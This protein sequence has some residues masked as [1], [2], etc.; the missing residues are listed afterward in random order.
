MNASSPSK[1]STIR[2]ILMSQLLLAIYLGFF[3]FVLNRSP[4]ETFVAGLVCALVAT[5]V[6]AFC[7]NLFLS[8]LEY[9]THFVIGLDIFFEG[10]F[11]HEGLGFYYCAVSFWVVFFCY[12]AYLFYARKPDVG[13]AGLDAVIASETQV[14][15]V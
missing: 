5:G 2:W 3:H 15:S 13:P 9:L 12:H 10:F 4:T 14:K 7:R 8:R 6:I 1:Y 11:P